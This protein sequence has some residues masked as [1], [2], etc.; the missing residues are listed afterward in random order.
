MIRLSNVVCRVAGR[1]LLDQATLTVPDG[2]RVGFV[3]RNG[4]GK[5]TL[6]RLL[7]GELAPDSGEI[8]IARGRRLGQVAQ[9]APATSI[10]IRDIVLAAD[11]E[12]AQL[13]TE[14]E[15]AQDPERVA[16]IHGRLRDIA[17]HAAPARAARILAGLGFDEAAQARPAAEFSG[18]WRMR[19]ALAAMLFREPHILLLDEPTNY[20]DLEGTLWLEAHLASYP[21]TV[22]IVSHDR[23]L[24][25]GAVD[26][27]IHLDQAKLSFWA[28]N[29][30]RF[31]EQL[32]EQRLLN[33]KAARKQAEER[34]H[35][36]AFVD[37]F[38]ASATK[39][40][41]AQSRLKRLAKMVPVTVDHQ[42][43]QVNFHFPAPAKTLASPLLAFDDVSV[44]YND[45]AILQHMSLRLDADDRIG[46][47]GSNGNGK[48]T[49]A[50]LVCQR[51][52]P[53]AGKLTRA[54]AL[55]AGYF[56]QHQLDE[57][58][59]DENVLMHLR[60]LMPAHSEA[61]VRAR[62]AQYGFSGDRS[63]TAVGALSG[64][65]RARLLLN[66]AA[67]YSPH[68]L[69]LD[70]PTNHL[71]MVAREALVKAIN[72]FSGAVILIS[73]DRSLL[74]ACVDRLWLVGN[75]TVTRFEGD[76]DDYRDHVLS[77][78]GSI[79]KDKAP[80][81]AA[82]K[83]AAPDRQAIAAARTRI[84]RLEQEIEQARQRIVAIDTLLADPKLYAREPKKAG[85]LARL[86]KNAGLGLG[87]AE[88]DWLKANEALEKLQTS[89][90]R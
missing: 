59:P 26:H 12:R 63:E 88:D 76:L 64:G 37:R 34:A 20:L 68:L 29:Y 80:P 60:R 11:E 62:A 19:V 41:Q 52:Q 90:S 4:A 45:R 85:E 47:L 16:I 71:D 58:R 86:R 32:A 8:D 25:N 70:E 15:S 23:D 17:A 13:L 33:Q 3:G 21:H 6:F 28:G 53:I 46:L 69:V 50:K 18:G 49:F 74:D 61:A 73:H 75:G 38:R 24:L 22:I 5:T 67:F 79:V 1:T 65:E 44:G 7:T 83:A 14:A 27:I 39:A 72:E 66:L 48:S 36:Q 81:K 87:L 51:L 42:E 10:A 82:A 56:A 84:Q 55:A 9:E 54:P 40:S 89:G 43:Q 57:L 77:A 35:L 31:A 30:D 2:A 78:A